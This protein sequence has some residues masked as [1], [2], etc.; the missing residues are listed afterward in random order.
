MSVA[1]EHLAL[2]ALQQIGA[3]TA[4][5]QLDQL[6]QQAAAE[7]WSYSQPPVASS[8]KAVTFYC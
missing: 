2:S 6:A 8:P 4:L 3:T 1:Y 7:D 5:A